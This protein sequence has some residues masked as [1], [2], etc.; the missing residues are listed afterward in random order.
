MTIFC[1]HG[2]ISG[3]YSCELPVA[4]ASACKGM[5]TVCVEAWGR[6]QVPSSFTVFCLLWF[7]AG[8]LT[9]S[10]AHKVSELAASELQV[11]PASWPHSRTEATGMCHHHAWLVCGY[12]R[13]ELRYLCLL[14]RTLATEPSPQPLRVCLYKGKYLYIQLPQR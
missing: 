6:Y 12:W 9:K 10:A 5:T 3:D 2:E 11:L 4:C 8:P 7:W 14:V 1:S 13:P